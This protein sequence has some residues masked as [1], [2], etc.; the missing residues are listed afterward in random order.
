MPADGSSAPYH[1]DTPDPIDIEIGARIRLRRKTLGLSQG[2]LAEQLAVSFQQV[3]KYERGANRVSGS[4]LVRVAASLETSVG[5]LVGETA[6]A[7]EV[8]DI[9]ST[10]LR[11]GAGQRLMGDAA[12]LGPDS[13]RILANVARGLLGEAV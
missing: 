7:V 5:A 8:D 4:T 6:N 10:L 11:S 9:V 1:H 12:K 3:Q 2:A 13:L